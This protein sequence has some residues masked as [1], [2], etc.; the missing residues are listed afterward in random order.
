MSLM[1][2]FVILIK[3]KLSRFATQNSSFEKFLLECLS[4]ARDDFDDEDDF[5]TVETDD[6]ES[7]DS[8]VKEE[9]LKENEVV[10][11]TPETPKNAF[12]S[13]HFDD[14]DAAMD[15]KWIR[16]VGGIAMKRTSGISLVHIPW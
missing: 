16:K 15:K 8:V 13:E 7:E 6:D 11:I 1:V 2:R 10:Y 9:I 3:A 14:A 5:A 4:S 12:F